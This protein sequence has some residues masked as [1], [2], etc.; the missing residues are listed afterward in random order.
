MNQQL[1]VALNKQLANWNVLY[2]KLHNYHWYVTGPEFFTLHEK[3]EEYYN[4]AG[5]YIDE[6]AE[7]ILTI[8]G[9][10][11]A[12]LKEYLETAT[13]EESNGK[14]S[15]TEMVD[16]LV[17]DFEQIVKDSKKI[18]ET[19]EDSQD[20]PTADLFIGIKTSLEQHIWM[21]NAFNKR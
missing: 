3:F 6:V 13:I 14:E 5:N 11:I 20:Q 9:K 19:A 2:T 15:S 1:V 12:T 4:E 21:L 7:R 18:I 8:K 17:N 16:A 10:P